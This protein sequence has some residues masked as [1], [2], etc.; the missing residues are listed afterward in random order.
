MN[1]YAAQASESRERRKRQ[2]TCERKVR[3]ASREHALA[4]N[5]GLEPYLCKFCG[6]WH[7]SGAVA[8]TIGRLRQRYGK[9]A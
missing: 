9:P 2:R 8:R 5:R 1:K 6:G 3:H 7:V 4:A